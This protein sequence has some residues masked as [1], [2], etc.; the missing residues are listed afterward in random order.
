MRVVI[1]SSGGKDSSYAVWWAML[2]GW[3]IAGIITVRIQGDDSM[4]FQVPS[5]SLAGLQAVSAGLPWLPI[6]IDGN[7]DG[8]IMELEAAIES[9]INGSNKPRSPT[10]SKSERDAA[11]WPSSWRWPLDLMRL[12]PHLPIDAIVVGALRSDYQKTRIEQ[13]C[14]RLGVISYTPLWHHNAEQH[15]L[16]LIEQGFEMMITSVTADGLGEEW[17]GKVL[18]ISN[19]QDLRRLSEKYRFNIDG[20]GGEYETAVIS[21]PWMQHRISTN[22]TTHWTGARG[23]VDIWSAELLEIS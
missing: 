7:E 8:E 23:W 14:Q 15:V 11:D 1:L 5:T 13:M 16:D 12:Q 22:Y 2:R 18:T 9:V 3:E 17:L 6:S 21:A 19:F 10:W 4:M 20:E